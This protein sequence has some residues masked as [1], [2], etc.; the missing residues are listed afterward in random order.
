VIIAELAIFPTSE[1]S[2]VSRFVKEAIRVIEASAC[3]P[4]R[5]HVHDHRGAGPQSA[6]PGDPRRPCGH[7]EMGAR[8]VH[9]DLRVDH[10]LDKEAT[11]ARKKAPSGKV[12]L[13]R[14]YK[15]DKLNR[16]RAMAEYKPFTENALKILRAR[17][18]MRNEEGEFLDKEPA[19]LFRR[20]AGYVASAEKTKKDQEKWAGKFFD[21]MMA[22]DFLPNSPTLTGA[23]RDMCLSAC[24]VL[25][26]EDSLDSIFETVK[27]AALV[28]KEG[29]GTGS[30]SAASVPGGASS[31]E[32]RASPRGRSLSSG[33]STP[34]PRPS[35]RAGR[36]AGPTWESCASTIPISKSSS[37]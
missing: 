16:S 32:P 15:T 36:A 3:A 28:H 17:Y 8:R 13:E 34:P 5:R 37:G 25:P 30:T 31:K 11:I 21:A 24:F 10:R 35:N 33:S 19:D 20:V 29:G 6:V 9:I 23:G 22:R 2:S 4:R 14:I 1:G 18:L 27:N 12:K 7:P 26:I